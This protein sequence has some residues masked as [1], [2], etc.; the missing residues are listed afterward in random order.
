MAF[1]SSRF[2]ITNW[3]PGGIPEV[4]ERVGH[5][6]VSPAWTRLQFTHPQLHGVLGKTL[7]SESGS[8]PRVFWSIKM[9]SAAG[10][11]GSSEGGAILHLDLRLK[12]IMEQAHAHEK[13]HGPLND[14]V[15]LI[16]VHEA[17]EL[18]LRSDLD[19]LTPSLEFELQALLAEAGAYYGLDLQARKSLYALLKGFDKLDKEN[20]PV[21]SQ[22]VLLF[23]AHDAQRIHTEQ[24][25]LKLARFVLGS[26]DY[27]AL[28]LGHEDQ[29]VKAAIAGILG[30]TPGTTAVADSAARAADVALEKPAAAAKPASVAPDSPGV[31]AKPAAAPAR[32]PDISASPVIT[33]K[34]AKP[35]MAAIPEDQKPVEIAYTDNARRVS[36]QAAQT[37][38]EAANILKQLGAVPG[39]KEL[40][41]QD[42]DRVRML[43]DFNRKME[44]LLDIK[45]NLAADEVL[46]IPEELK[47]QLESKRLSQYSCINFQGRVYSLDLSRLNLQDIQMFGAKLSAADFSR[48]DLSGTNLIQAQLEGANFMGAFMLG[49]FLHRANMRNATLFNANLLGAELQNADLTGANMRRAYCKNTILLNTELAQAQMHFSDVESRLWL[50]E[51]HRSLDDQWVKLRDHSKTEIRYAFRYLSEGRGIKLLDD[52]R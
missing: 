35:V 39:P 4:K 31:A 38:K 1:V 45:K 24:G 37:L 46:D 36:Q 42:V 7:G 52:P 33:D 29:V 2:G 9:P 34:P 20:R 26:P 17:R 47:N 16:L 44:S 50:A 49:T 25:L 18:Q 14:F 12:R 30:K 15:Y 22:G 48:S 5:A 3:Q 13:W 6:L 43:T 40:P 51:V 21:F 28:A 10:V 19:T 23:E 11:T 27:S 8:H 41:I 32:E